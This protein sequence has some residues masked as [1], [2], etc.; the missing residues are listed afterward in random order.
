MQTPKL[1]RQ[2]RF[3]QKKVR[4][5]YSPHLFQKKL[6]PNKVSKPSGGAF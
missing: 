6:R 1:K 5:Q 3:D 4:D 2:T